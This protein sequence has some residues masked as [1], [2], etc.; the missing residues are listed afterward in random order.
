ML[1]V[2]LRFRRRRRL[3]VNFDD[4]N[5]GHAEYDGNGD[6]QL[7]G[8]GFLNAAAATFSL[9]RGIPFIGICGVGMYVRV[10]SDANPKRSYLLRMFSPWLTTV[11]V[12]SSLKRTTLSGL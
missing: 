6:Q 1:S 11:T 12:T 2:C 7:T 9:G 4:D 5:H 8:K 3:E 10:R